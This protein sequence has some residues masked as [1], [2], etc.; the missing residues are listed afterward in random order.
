MGER[1]RMAVFDQRT[2]LTCFGEHGRRC[3]ASVEKKMHAGGKRFRAGAQFG[4]EF[5]GLAPAFGTV[6]NGT[7]GN[8]APKHLFETEGLCAELNVV[9][10][11]SGLVAAPFVF[12]GKR[13]PK[14]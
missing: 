12:D 11:A 2:T 13:G 9:G 6:I 10:L 5:N 14:A 3:G 1:M 4:R 7:L 8:G